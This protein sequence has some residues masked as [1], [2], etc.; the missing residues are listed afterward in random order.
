MLNHPIQILVFG[1]LNDSDRSVLSCPS[2]M[3][4]FLSQNTCMLCYSDLETEYR[5][6]IHVRVSDLKHLKIGDMKVLSNFLTQ[7]M[8]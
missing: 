4:V 6:M 7:I 2:S 5:D 8:R 1:I 3:I